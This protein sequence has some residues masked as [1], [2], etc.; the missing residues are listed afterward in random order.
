VEARAIAENARKELAAI[1]AGLERRVEQAVAERLRA[2][3]GLSAEK[4]TAELREQFIAVLG[5]DLRNP[6]ASVSAGIK[7]LE[8]ENLGDG[9]RLVANLMRDSL[10]R[11]SEIIDNLLDL[12]RGRL[13]GGIALNL[14][15]EDSLE[16]MLRQIVA[17]SQMASAEAAIRADFSIDEPVCCDRLRLGQLVSN[18]LGNALTHGS[19]AEPIHFH[20][21]TTAG[22]LELWVANSG[23]P[24]PEP[25]L[26][27]LFQPFFRGEARESRQ[28][29]GLGLYIAAEIARAHGGVISVSST[30]AE[31]R[32]TFTMPLRP[33]DGASPPT[34]G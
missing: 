5:H 23:E 12:A 32:F 13:G 27:R 34:V 33:G 24:I 8:R 3:R 7:L 22:T 16:P 26:A 31:T 10:R 1:N 14:A 21:A 19:P 25:A 18:L 4:E 29:L 20:A 30:A 15:V 28:G 6:L 9:G 2:E 17:E 11:M